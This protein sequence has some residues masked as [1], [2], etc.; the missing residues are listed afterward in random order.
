MFYLVKLMLMS[1]WISSVRVR[2][3]LFVCSA[4]FL[5][6]AC[7]TYNDAS[8]KIAN[9]V[10]P[11]RMDIVQGNFISRE[12][13]AQLHIGMTR[14]EVR[15]LLGTPLLTDMF[16]AN[17][18]DYVFNFKRGNSDVVQQRRYT[19][20]F[21]GD[22]LTSFSGDPLPSEYELISEIDGIKQLPVAKEVMAKPEAAKAVTAPEGASSGQVASPAAGGAK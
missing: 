21:D 13:A 11:Y 17:R 2:K 14:D 1:S 10:T 3:A 4:A 18:W 8:R 6:G 15:Q 16:H 12:A 22:Q 20:L 5:L 9:A 7:S 19:L